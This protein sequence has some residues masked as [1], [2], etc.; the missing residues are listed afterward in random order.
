MT[1]K[2]AEDGVAL[3]VRSILCDSEA[4]RHDDAIATGSAAINVIRN[5]LVDIHRLKARKKDI[6]DERQAR[7]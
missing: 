2:L 6:E 5:L 1:Q 4:G 7:S 3:I